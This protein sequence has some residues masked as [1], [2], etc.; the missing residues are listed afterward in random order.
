MGVG[1]GAYHLEHLLW[2]ESSGPGRVEGL[3]DQEKPCVMS[4]TD[5]RVLVFSIF[6]NI[7]VGNPSERHER[8]VP[9][10]CNF[11]INMTFQKKSYRSF[12][13]ITANLLGNNI[14]LE[15]L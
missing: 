15:F 9:C 7:N 10:F 12:K 8:S 14:T 6:R 5:F 2:P 13:G 1:F 4:A 11:Y 3:C